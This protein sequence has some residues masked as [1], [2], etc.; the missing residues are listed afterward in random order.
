MFAHRAILE[1]HSDF[2]KLGFQNPITPIAYGIVKLH[3]HIF[4]FLVVILFI[5]GYL[6]YTSYKF[7]Y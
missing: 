3:D 6:L 2:W 7:Y 1:N 4:F 5:V